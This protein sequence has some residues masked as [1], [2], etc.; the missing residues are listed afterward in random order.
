MIAWVV[1]S[2][3]LPARARA[4]E[5]VTVGIAANFSAMSDSSSNPYADYF[6]DAIGMAFSESQAALSAKGVRVELKELDYGN[7][8]LKVIETAR[9]A[10][11]SDAVAV[12]GYIYSSDA[13][14]AGPVFSQ[15]HLLLVTPTATAERVEKLG[16]YVRRTCFDDAYQGRILA[17]YAHN[18]EIRTAGI[19]YA[20][21]CAYCNSLRAAFKKRFEALGGRVLVEQAVLSSDDPYDSAVSVFKNNPV[22]AI[23]VPNYERVSATIISRLIDAGIR[24]KLWLG[25]DGWGDSI[26]LFSRIIGERPFKGYAIAHWYRDATPQSKD[27][28]EKF[29]RLYGKP[30]VDTAVLAYDAAKL[31]I[32]GLL[33]AKRLD[34]EGV[35]EAVE[36]IKTFDGVT[37]RLIYPAGER[38]PIKPAVLMRVETGRGNAVERL[39]GEQ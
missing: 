34:R 16:R 36:S 3:L 30:P 31:V 32:R 6:R 4:L 10:A 7:D 18:R 20:A 26:D 21:D 11:A 38:T 2:L 9:A 35:L 15:A 13:L 5:K 22:Q 33:E 39:I 37:G 29:T 25:G 17:D 28:V 12:I 23:F 1:L 19:V 24:P 8:K 27:F 14:L